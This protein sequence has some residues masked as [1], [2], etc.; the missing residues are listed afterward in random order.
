MAADPVPAT[1]TIAAPFPVAANAASKSVSRFTMIPGNAHSSDACIRTFIS[2]C[3]VP[4]NPAP[5]AKTAFRSTLASRNASS[6]AFSISRVAASTPTR[7]GFEGPAM[8]RATIPPAESIKTHSVFVPPPSNPSTY[9][10]QKAYV[11]NVRLEWILRRRG[12]ENI[13]IERRDSL[14]GRCKATIL[15][16]LFRSTPHAMRKSHSMRIHPLD[17]AIVIAYLL[18]VTALGINF[19]GGEKD[20]RD[21][22]LGGRTAL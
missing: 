14:T 21:Y 6:A 1:S 22:F 11:K 19:R 3:A 13:L 4:A 16:A 17:L 8:L 10:T 12:Y 7:V 2:A 5:I 15:I 20:A 18:G 9:C